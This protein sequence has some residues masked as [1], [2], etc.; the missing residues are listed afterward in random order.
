MFEKTV[1][2]VKHYFFP[3]VVSTF[4]TALIL[5]LIFAVKKS[6]ENKI[7]RFILIFILVIF[8]SAVIMTF[9]YLFGACS[10]VFVAIVVVS[11]MI[12]N[13]GNVK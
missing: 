3:N 5:F 13:I 10:L 8:Q 12:E 9:L 2:L 11:V 4:L 7:L 1:F 6:I